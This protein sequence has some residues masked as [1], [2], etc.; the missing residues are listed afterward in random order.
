MNSKEK[1]NAESFKVQPGLDLSPD[2]RIS[3]GVQ[4]EIDLRIYE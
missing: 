4:S 3:A 1:L 2:D